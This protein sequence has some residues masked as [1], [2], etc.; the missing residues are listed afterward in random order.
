MWIPQSAAGEK[1]PKR[2]S[3]IKASFCQRENK[4]LYFS[5]LVYFLS[6]VTEDAYTHAK[7]SV[8]PKYWKFSFWWKFPQ[9]TSTTGGSWTWNT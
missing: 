7:E 2:W 4:A 3:Q 9:L 8:L 1:N 6:I 5:A